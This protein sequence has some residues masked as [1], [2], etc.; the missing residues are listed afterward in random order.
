MNEVEKYIQGFDAVTQQRLQT[1]R[2]IVAELVPEAHESIK[3]G[4]IGYMVDGKPLVY[5][6]GFTRHIGFYATPS[7]QAAFK[8]ALAPYKQGKGS[9]QFPHT[10]PLPIPLIRDMVRYR[11]T[12]TRA[13]TARTAK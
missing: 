11:Q 6:G 10:Q 8:A 1:L 7:G 12:D 2:S 5:F 9:V 3:Y 13:S 4:V